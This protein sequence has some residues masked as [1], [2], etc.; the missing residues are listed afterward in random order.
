MILQRGEVQRSCS[1]GYSAL[2]KMLSVIHAASP[3]QGDLNQGKGER[4]VVLGGGGAG[5][6]F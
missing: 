1:P 6:Y 2:P 3:V 4:V 5:Y